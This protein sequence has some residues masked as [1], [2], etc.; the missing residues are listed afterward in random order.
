MNSAKTETI[1]SCF[2]LKFI[3]KIQSFL[4]FCNFYRRFIHEYSEIALS[5]TNEIKLIKFVWTKNIQRSFNL[6][7]R[8]FIKNILQKHFNSER[9]IEINTNA[10]EFVLTVI[11]L[12]LQDDDHW[13]FIAFHS[14]KLKDSKK[15]YVTHDQE[16]SIIVNTFKIWKDYLKKTKYK[17]TSMCDYNNLRYFMTFKLLI[18]TQTHWA[19]FLI[20]CVFK[21]E[22]RAR[23]KN[24]TDASSRRSD[25]KSKKK[26]TLMSLLK[27]VAITL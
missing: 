23:K 10:N 22:H 15:N 11:I 12:Q 6:L 14:R 17:I 13:H 16:L 4:E 25:Y 8:T 27:L 3:K 1:L 2:A 7:K 20:N 21:I 26:I 19:K 24:S 9:R 18:C 5:L